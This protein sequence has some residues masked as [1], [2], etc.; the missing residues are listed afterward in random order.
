MALRVK[1]FEESL[2]G[3]GPIPQSQA[4]DALGSHT[5]DGRNPR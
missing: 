4:V 1:P 5:V 3:L 2:Y